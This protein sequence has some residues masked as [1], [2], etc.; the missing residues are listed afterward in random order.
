MGTI[1]ILTPEE[2]CR[3]LGS[4]CRKLRLARNLSQAVLAA[5]AGGSLSS[6]RRLEERGQGTLLLLARVAQALQVGHQFEPL[7]VLPVTRI[8]DAEREAAL[9]A[10]RRAGRPRPQSQ[11]PA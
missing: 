5:M 3:E 11:G 10:R 1:D 7:M 9:C 6:I 4:R 2:I 8:A